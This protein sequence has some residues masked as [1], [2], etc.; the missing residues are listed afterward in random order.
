MKMKR[1]L[2]SFLAVLGMVFGQGQLAA[3]QDRNQCNTCKQQ[4]TKDEH[5]VL[6]C[7]KQV[8][9]DIKD[10]KHCCKKGEEYSH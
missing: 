1:C 8:R 3:K 4:S 10:A 2:F 9:C 7:C 5:E 6:D